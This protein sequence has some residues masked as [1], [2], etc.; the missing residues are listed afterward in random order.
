MKTI[1]ITGGPC[2]GKTSAIGVLRERLRAA[3]I[4]AVYVAE[5]GTDLILEGITPASL[6]SMRAFQTRVAALQIE[7]EA[8]AQEEALALEEAQRATGA[9]AGTETRAEAGTE[10]RTNQEVLVICDRGIC[11]G[12][13]YLSPE[14]Y[15]RV[16]EANRLDAANLFARYDAVFCLESTAKIKDGAYTTA[17]NTARSETPEEAAALDDRTR[18]AW[19]AHPCFHFIANEESFAEKA[20][21]LVAGILALA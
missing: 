15:A 20:E 6:G 14:D 7:R 12:A 9:K 18:A 13:A 11:D 5:A 8:R 21:K 3:D 10:T 17:N 19:E 2:S 1:V 16:L 4:K